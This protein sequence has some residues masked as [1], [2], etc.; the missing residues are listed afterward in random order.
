MKK[1]MVFILLFEMLASLTFGHNLK[2]NIKDKTGQ[3]IPF[4]TVFFKEGAQGTTT[5]EQGDFEIDLP[6]GKYTVTYRSLGF[7][8]LTETIT[9]T[10]NPLTIKIVLA[11]QIQ[12]LQEI[13]ISAGID[14]AYPIM[15]KV[16]SLSYVHLNQM[17]SYSAT[18]YLRG[19][20]KVENIPG[21]FRNQLKKQNIDIKS[22]DILVQESVNQITFRAPDKYDLKIKSINS[23]FPKGIDFQVTD[24]LGSSLYQDNINILISPVGK[25]AFSHYNFKYEGFS[26]EGKN[27]VNKIKVMPKRKSKLLFEGYLYIMEDYWCLKQADLNFETPIGT[28]N[29]YMT[30]DEVSPSIWLP[31]SHNFSFDA[32]MM[33]I[34]GNGKFSTSMKYT[35]LQFNQTVLAML[36]LPVPGKTE[37]TAV[38]PAKQTTAKAIKA[39]K[40]TEKKQVKI[41][42]LLE[43]KDLTAH[44]MNKLSRLLEAGHNETIKDSVKSLE[45][46]ESVKVQVDP[47]AANSDSTFWNTMR[48]IPLAKEEIK[49][50]QKRDSVVLAVQSRPKSVV[51]DKHKVNV[52]FITPLLFGKRSTFRDSTWHYIYYGLINLNRF[53]F[54]AVDGFA[55][56][57]EI[58]LTK[59]FKP[60]R[61]LQFHPSIAYAFN[62]EAWMGKLHVRYNYAPLHRGTF[63]LKG[64]SY[65]ED[66]NDV[67]SAISP[68]FN[69][70]SSLFFKT[71]FARFYE[72]RYL[73][74][75]NNVDLFNGLVLTTRFEW[76]NVRQLQN[77]TNFSF[78]RGNTDYSPN[79]PANDE[80]SDSQ[81]AGQ[82]STKAGIRLE[83]T[84]KYYYRI[85]NGVKY[86]SHSDFPT[87][88][89]GYDKGIKNFFSSSSDFDYFSA[90]IKYAK[91]LSES[92]SLE[93]EFHGGIFTKNNQLH[94]SDF[95]HMMTQTSPVL[96]HEYRHSFYVPNYYALSA[97]DRFIGG[98]VSYK[99]PF[100]LLKYLPVLSNTLWREMIWAGFYSSPYHPYHTEFGYTILEFFYSTNV[101]IFV[102]FD[103]LNISKVGLNLAFRIAY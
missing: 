94:F 86:M 27:I 99:S 83:Y 56:N 53:T 22:G 7:T 50:F 55:F 58:L 41:D 64:G 42:Q 65:T 78:I 90:G 2:G 11:E 43:K 9:L 14:R 91:D 38:Q 100:I 8:P 32:S 26:Y 61:S 29:L 66:F 4:A 76:K 85:R 28:V 54:N 18:A 19:T 57:Q 49:S 84:P 48:P 47:A 24:M 33:G 25:N 69:S 30:Y 88:Y 40:A 45:I 23:S 12:E 52:G 87:I 95:A 98:F 37:Q 34:R 74:F 97:A 10:R 31:V 1:L 71:N 6:P 67:E 89:I 82:I 21:I 20:I 46:A 68:F 17:Q 59:N 16:I 101:G 36:N 39:I 79:L 103:K 81:L 75:S 63:E 51:F 93:W 5:N 62:R 77:S 96:P 35:D 72:D 44:E 92:S 15:R 80:V 70:V 102:G 13:T 3:P 73:K 60:G